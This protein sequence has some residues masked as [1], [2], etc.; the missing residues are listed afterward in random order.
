L[1]AVACTG[2]AGVAVGVTALAATTAVLGMV[3][4]P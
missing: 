4:L 2:G 3:A 1:I